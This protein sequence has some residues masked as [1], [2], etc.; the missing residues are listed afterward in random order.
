[1]SEEERGSNSI[2]VAIWKKDNRILSLYVRFGLV[3]MHRR[4]SAS[5]NA[6]TDQ[7][8]STQRGCCT[9]RPS[10]R[11]AR[12]RR[13]LMAVRRKSALTASASPLSPLILIS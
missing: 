11:T 2:L 10:F 5:D 4:E 1:M 3:E 9:D 8:N 13:S 7:S 6:T 12:L